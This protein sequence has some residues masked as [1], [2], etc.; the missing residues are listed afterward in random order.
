VHRGGGQGLVRGQRL[1]G[2]L[3]NFGAHQRRRRWGSF[4]STTPTPPPRPLGDPEHIKARIYAKAEEFATAD[5]AWAGKSRF[6]LE[7]LRKARRL[8][9]PAERAVERGLAAP[10]T[11]TQGQKAAAH[12]QE[13]AAMYLRTGRAKTYTE[14]VRMANA[15]GPEVARLAGADPATMPGGMS[16][17]AKAYAMMTGASPR[18]YAVDELGQPVNRPPALSDAETKL[19]NLTEDDIVALLVAAPRGKLVEMRGLLWEWATVTAGR[20][21][22][23]QAPRGKDGHDR[24]NV[25]I[26]RVWQKARQERLRRFGY[27]D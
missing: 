15:A 27:T 19:K 14:A 26:E 10:D 24:V 13:L 5:P 23:G 20:Y 12:Q 17:G 9:S 8:F 4:P 3:T 16:E 21:P 7:H 25:L 6:G 18:M 22:V 1:A 11:R 2:R